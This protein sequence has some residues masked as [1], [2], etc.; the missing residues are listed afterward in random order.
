VALSVPEP[1]PSVLA[2]GAPA[3][4]SP[5]RRVGGYRHG[6]GADEPGEGR[7]LGGKRNVGGVGG[8]NVSGG[9]GAAMASTRRDRQRECDDADPSSGAYQSYVNKWC[10]LKT[11]PCRR[12]CQR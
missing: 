2:A 9:K 10:D 4:A 1:A 6:L 12:L 5:V 11:K 7:R 8:P 3:I